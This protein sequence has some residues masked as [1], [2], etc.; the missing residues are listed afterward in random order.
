MLNFS[1]QKKESFKSNNQL[2]GLMMVGSQWIDV[3]SREARE[4]N[5]NL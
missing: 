5:S 2:D 3:I 4:Q 1:K